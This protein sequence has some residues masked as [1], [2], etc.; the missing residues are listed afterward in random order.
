MQIQFTKMQGIGN[1]FVVIDAIN[2]PVSLT[3]EQ[4]RRIAD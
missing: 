1:D 4:A 2:Q 3:P